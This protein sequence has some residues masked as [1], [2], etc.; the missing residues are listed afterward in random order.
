MLKRIGTCKKRRQGSINSISP[1]GRRSTRKRG[2]LA[3]AKGEYR[4]ASESLADAATG[5]DTWLPLD[6]FDSSLVVLGDAYCATDD[7]RASVYYGRAL[8]KSRKERT[9]P[10]ALQ[11]LGGVAHLLARSGELT[12]AMELAL[13]VHG[14][15]L[16]WH[17]HRVRTQMLIEELEVPAADITTAARQRAMECDAWTVVDEVLATIPPAKD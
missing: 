12:R 8:H 14:H 11:A 1:I 2:R 17:E 3:Y 15:P 5:D 4:D 6:N 13:L 10:R 9:L 16:T 7:D